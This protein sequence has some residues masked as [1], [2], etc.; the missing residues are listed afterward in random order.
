MDC[1]RLYL[2][3][4]LHLQSSDVKLKDGRNIVNIELNQLMKIKKNCKLTYQLLEPSDSFIN[5]LQMADPDSF[6]LFDYLTIDCVS[7]VGS[8]QV[9]RPASGI[10]RLKMPYRSTMSNSRLLYDTDLPHERGK[11]NSIAK[12]NSN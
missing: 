4:Q 8:T 5:A 10:R 3:Q 11:F 9:E 2:L 1:S 12:V 7:P 6:S